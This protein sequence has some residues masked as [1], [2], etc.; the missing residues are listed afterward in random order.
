MP[1]WKKVILSGSDAS[2]NS[3]DVTTNVAITGS[4]ALS[5]SL[6]DYT[7]TAGTPDQILFTTSTGVEWRD[8]IAVSAESLVII[9]KNVT[10]SPIPKGTPVYFTGSGTSGNLVGVIPAD[11][12]N[13]N[14][15]PA[16]GVLAEAIAAGAEGGVYIYGYING[17][18]TSA[19]TTGD[20]VFVAVGGGYTNVKPTGSALIQKLGNVEK[21]DP[22]NGSGAIQGPSW[23]NDLPNVQPGYTW[24]GDSNSVP[25]AVSTA[26][27]FVTSASYAISSSLSAETVLVKSSDATFDYDGFVTFFSSTQT[28]AQTLYKD[29]TGGLKYNPTSNKLTLTGSFE[30]TGGITG[31]LLGTA[32]FATSASHT[33]NANNAISASYALT[34][35]FASSGNN[36]VGTGTT[37]LSNL[38]LRSPSSSGSSVTTTTVSSIPEGSVDLI[39]ISA[40]VDSA[41]AMFIDYV[42]Y[43][44]AKN[45][46]RAGNLRLTWNTSTTVFDETST[47]DIGDTSGFVFTVDND[48]GSFELLATNT[49]GQDMY[50]IYEYKLLYIV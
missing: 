3:L 9:G 10:A 28:E 36:F 19:F 17:V 25:Q 12:G 6:I 8:N 20:D 46:K 47:I 48:G 16:G 23:Y 38:N 35:S 15:M 27:L 49:T 13:P 30:V 43:D 24:V 45:N 31:S 40:G 7:G 39:L 14:L 34:S 50:L 33:L 22:T 26:S 42:L 32:S 5:G 2:L 18:N 37:S 44:L 21:I 1:S 29:T 4:L 11:A 41:E